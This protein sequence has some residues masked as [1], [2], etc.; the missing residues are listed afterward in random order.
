MVTFAQLLT[1]TNNTYDVYIYDL[2]TGT[3]LLVSQSYSPGAAGKPEFLYALSRSQGADPTRATGV[4]NM[5]L[6]GTAMPHVLWQLQG[7]QEAVWEGHPDAQGN[8]QE[9]IYDVV[10]ADAEKRKMLDETVARMLRI[11]A[12]VRQAGGFFGYAENF[13]YAPSVQKEREIVGGVL[14]AMEKAIGRKTKG[15]LSPFLTHTNNTPNILAEMGV[16]YLCD[17]TADDHPFPF[18]VRKGSLISV[19]YTVELN[20]IPA[21][22]KAS[23]GVYLSLPGVTPGFVDKARAAMGGYTNAEGRPLGIRPNLLVVGRGNEAAARTLLNAEFIIGDPTAGG[24]QSNIWRNS[25]DLL[26]V[27]Q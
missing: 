1:D 20:D 26:V 10:W 22:Q 17:Y 2:Q 7:V 13:V 8:V 16:E 27:R 23:A 9:R 21:F 3:K 24:S 25:A 5:V 6:P 19:P 12:A 18:N 11:A 15:W 14:K 4:N